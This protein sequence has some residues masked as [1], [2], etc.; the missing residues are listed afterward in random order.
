MGEADVQ[1]SQ[2]LVPI[3]LSAI[4]VFFASFIT[5]MLLPFHKKDWQGVPEEDKF[6]DFIRSM[7][8]APGQYCFPWAA[9]PKEMKQPEVAEKMKRG[10]HGVLH[11]WSDRPGMGRSL[12]LTALFYLVVSVL[13]GYVTSEAVVAGADFLRTFQIS[14]TVAIMA[15]ALGFIPNAIWFGK[16]MGIVIKDIVDGIAFGLITGIIFASFWPALPA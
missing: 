13:A 10:P 7:N 1:L 3:V 2:L 5:W 9:D 8:I 11:I 12:V 16:S 6:L 4:A 15:Y 14:G